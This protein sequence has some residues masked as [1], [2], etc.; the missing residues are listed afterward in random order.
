MPTFAVKYTQFGRQELLSVVM[1]G[2]MAELHPAGNEPY[3]T[4]PALIIQCSEDDTTSS[5]VGYKGIEDIPIGRVAANEF[6]R[7]QIKSPGG[8]PFSIIFS[9]IACLETC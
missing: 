4:N 6:W 3:T 1:P 9:H 2:D 7:L 8:E 5:L